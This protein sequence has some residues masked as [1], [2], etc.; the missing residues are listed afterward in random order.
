MDFKSLASGETMEQSE[1]MND[2]RTSSK[3]LLDFALVQKAL[4]RLQARSLMTLS[5]DETDVWLED[6]AKTPPWK[7]SRIGEFSGHMRDVWGFF[8]KLQYAPPPF[9]PRIVDNS[10]R[11]LEEYRI[12]QELLLGLKEITL[13]DTI[14]C[15][16]KA[17]DAFNKYLKGKYP[18]YSFS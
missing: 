13:D 17:I 14:P 9:I 8:E 1:T 10:E 18:Q 4:L 6:L 16:S 3:P 11:A 15:K 12:G 2:E 7:L 5:E